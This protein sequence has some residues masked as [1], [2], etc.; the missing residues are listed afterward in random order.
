[1]SLWIKIL[2]LMVYR[3][4]SFLG[5]CQPSDPLNAPMSLLDLL[6]SYKD[7]YLGGHPKVYNLYFRHLLT[8]PLVSLAWWMQTMMAVWLAL[9]EIGR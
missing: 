7:T 9:K 1:M 2:D 8:D 5:L 4:R 3:I 6:A